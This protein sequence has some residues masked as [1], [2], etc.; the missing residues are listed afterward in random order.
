MP[1]KALLGTT[2]LRRRERSVEERGRVVPGV[3]MHSSS[4]GVAIAL[5]LQ[6]L[7]RRGAQGLLHA[8]DPDPMQHGVPIVERRLGGFDADLVSPPCVKEASL[9]L[10]GMLSGCWG[11]RLLLRPSP[12]QK[13]HHSCFPSSLSRCS[14]FTRG[15]KA[16][17]TRFS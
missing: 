4:V 17:C 1:R 5:P 8:G 16:S 2:S 10:G 6:L 9:E 11:P 15:S 14:C 3:L 12:S 7:V 13:A